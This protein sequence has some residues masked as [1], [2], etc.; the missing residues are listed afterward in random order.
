MI[1]LKD[2]IHDNKFSIIVKP[3]SKKNEIIDYDKEKEALKINIK[4]EPENNKANIEIIK[5]FKKILKKDIKIIT[6]KTSKKK[7]LKII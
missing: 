1:N 4:A 2:Y 3:N 6:G 7:V 5:F